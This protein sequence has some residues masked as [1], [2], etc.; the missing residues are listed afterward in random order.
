MTDNRANLLKIVNGPACAERNPGL[1]Q[2]ARKIYKLSTTPT[3]RA[4][5]LKPD[6]IEKL[7]FI[8]SD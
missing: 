8:E 7:Q 5:A 3:E 4:P 6:F 1:S 2:V